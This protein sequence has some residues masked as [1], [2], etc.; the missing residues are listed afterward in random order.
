MLF[1]GA[2]DHF[3]ALHHGRFW[4]SGPQRDTMHAASRHLSDSQGSDI[5][6]WMRVPVSWALM[7]V[8]HHSMHYR[9]TL[10]F[11]VVRA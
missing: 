2:R 6:N 4:G 8:I 7:S 3:S 5:L 10:V 9:Q 1:G 11:H